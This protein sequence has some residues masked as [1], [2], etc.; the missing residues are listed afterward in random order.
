V[1][2]AQHRFIA[3]A[4]WEGRLKTLFFGISIKA[5]EEQEGRS[6]LGKK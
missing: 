1:A 2:R 6:E 3:A 4:F 5:E